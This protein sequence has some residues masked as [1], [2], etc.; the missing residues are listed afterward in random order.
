MKLYFTWDPYKAK[1]NRQKHS[2]SFEEAASVFTDPLALI[3][4]DELHFEQEKREI[5]IGR[6]SHDRLV[7]VSFV[8]REQQIRI[9]SARITTRH[10]RQDYEEQGQF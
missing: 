4:E 6:S 3:F 2:V 1:I 5:I 7:L 9:I 10:E 8:E